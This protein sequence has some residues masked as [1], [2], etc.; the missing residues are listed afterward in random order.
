[1]SSFILLFVSYIHMGARKYVDHVD[2]VKTSQ[3]LLQCPLWLMPLFSSFTLSYMGT[4]LIPLYDSQWLDCVISK[5][6]TLMM[7]IAIPAAETGITVFVLT[8]WLAKLEV[9]MGAGCLK[10]PVAW[11]DCNVNPAAHVRQANET[12][13][14]IFILTGQMILLFLSRGMLRL[15][16]SP[17]ERKTLG[18]N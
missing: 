14:G 1:M 16:D 12:S 17:L 13:Q 7:L 4:E 8:V 3:H 18:L 10:H 2:L 6:C 15:N 9:L 11:A 5:T